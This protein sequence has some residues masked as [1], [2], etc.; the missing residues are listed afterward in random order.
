MLGTESMNF[1]TN[2]NPEVGLWW[3]PGPGHTPETRSAARVHSG[4]LAAWKLA[5]AA[6]HKRLS[7]VEVTR[8][9]RNLR[10][11]Q[12]TQGPK[13]GRFRW[14]WEE[15]HPHDSNASFFTGLG[16][17]VF[18]FE[19]GP[20]LTEPDRS[21][22]LAMLKDLRPWF[23]GELSRLSKNLRYPN[24][25]LGDLVCA[26]LLAEALNDDPVPLEAPLARAASYYQ[27]EHWGW[28]EHLSDTYAKVIQF[29]LTA[30][31]L[32][33]RRLP[34][35]LR[36]QYEALLLD[37]NRLDA[38]FAK[39]P[40][41]PAIR[42]YQFL[43]SPQK[44]GGWTQRSF[45]ESI[46]TAPKDSGEGLFSALLLPA[47]REKFHRR[48]KPAAQGNPFPSIP[49]FG[50]AK[51][52]VVLDKRYR[53]G[54]MSRYPLMKGTEQPAWGLS[55]QSMPVAYWNP[56]GDWAYLQWEASIEKN[57]QTHPAETRYHGGHVQLSEQTRPPIVG[58]TFG[59]R[60]ENQLVV[61]RRMPRWAPDWTRIADRF[62]IV[63]GTFRD[64]IETT[65]T[66]W[67]TLTLSYPDHLLRVGCYPLTQN[68][69]FEWSRPE[70]GRLD[71][72]IFYPRP[73]HRCSP[74]LL[75]LWI[76]QAGT[77]LPALPT[78]I[79]HHHAVLLR[80]SSGTRLLWSIHPNVKQPEWRPLDD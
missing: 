64:A 32:Y 8:V 51:A 66:Q 53:M 13:R 22:L 67:Q 68:V 57:R 31:L 40:R 16:L 37:L 5:A 59:C 14:Y 46:R 56:A 39:G 20:L 2:W 80:F 12:E 54:A 75:L 24:K 26:W 6:T 55:W 4:R 3:V 41:V 11:M 7:A 36:A 61:L 73:T 45:I 25:T 78:V 62:R 34:R 79:H 76:W 71:W 18:H 23:A 63:A 58:E 28:G 15:S 65:E 70:T 30:L 35:T 50:G 72:T 10:S 69:S 19:A 42:S 33:G 38:L 17:L 74:A 1:H 77:T 9:L 43:E 29:E 52:E 48:Y 60:V 44:P 27:D 47:H 49:C 21:L